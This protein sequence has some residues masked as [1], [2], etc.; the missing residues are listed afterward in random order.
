M[1][2]SWCTHSPFR[3]FFCLHRE[4]FENL[5]GR[6]R[7]DDE[8]KPVVIDEDGSPQAARIFGLWHPTPPPPAPAPAIE[9][10]AGGI[11]SGGGGSGEEEDG[12]AKALR[13][14]SPYKDT[15]S[16]LAELVRRGLKTLVF[17]K[18]GK[19]RARGVVSCVLLQRPVPT[20]PVSLPARLLTTI[21]FKYSCRVGNP[22]I[23][24]GTS[25]RWCCRWQ[26]SSCLTISGA[27][28][29]P[30]GEKSAG[31]MGE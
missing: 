19:A 12:E 13:R 27:K 17:V 5:T 14:R 24:C 26:G 1:E 4:H 18:V 11:L 31:G 28:S 9:G 10:K 23:R 22:K 30:T 16:L 21:A 25:P 3:V 29:P 8:E 15:A 2:W 7:G 20:H 6:G